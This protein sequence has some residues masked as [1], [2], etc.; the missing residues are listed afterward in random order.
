MMTEFQ[1]MCTQK[2]KDISAAPLDYSDL[3]KWSAK[4]SGP[5]DSC[6]AGMK[7]ELSMEFPA[8]YPF[9]PPTMLFKT[10]IYHPNIDMSGRICLDL[11]KDKWS[12]VV[13]VEGLL[14]CIQSLLEEPNP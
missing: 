10:P 1:N 3:S 12:A 9:A 7:F 2:N 14:L 4:V 6:Y 11:L 5:P 13:T 8:N